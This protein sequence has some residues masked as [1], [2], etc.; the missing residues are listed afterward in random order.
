MAKKPKADANP[1]AKALYRIG[2]PTA[3]HVAIEDGK[4]VIYHGTAML[5]LKGR[6]SIRLT[7]AEAA[8]YSNLGLELVGRDRV[9][10]VDDGEDDSAG[11]D[12]PAA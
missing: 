8:K 5:G 4:E 12:G 2:N 11:T 3:V 10:V 6:T 7:P 1:D 9:E